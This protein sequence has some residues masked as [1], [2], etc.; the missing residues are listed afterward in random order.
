MGLDR[1]QRTVLV[2]AKTASNSEI[3]VPLTEEAYCYLV[4]VIASDLRLQCRFKD[5]PTK[6]FPFFSEDPSLLV[7]EGMDFWNLMERL[8]SEDPDTVRSETFFSKFWIAGSG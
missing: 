3:A 8:A 6:I 1:L 5:L 4:V 2:R 7:V